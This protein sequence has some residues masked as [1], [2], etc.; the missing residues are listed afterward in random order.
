[1]IKICKNSKI[2]QTIQIKIEVAKTYKILI[3]MCKEVVEALDK[4][5]YPFHNYQLV[6][7]IIRNMKSR[8]KRACK[9]NTNSNIINLPKTTNLLN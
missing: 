1:M 8:T 5:E 6:K 4:M 2:F 9:I 7:D 3:Q